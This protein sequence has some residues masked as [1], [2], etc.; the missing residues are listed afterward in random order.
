M[1]KIIITLSVIIAILAISTGIFFYIKAN[2]TVYNAETATGNTAGNLSNGGLFCEY[3]D[4]I[5][6][7]NPYDSNRLY[8]MN[9]DCTDARKLNDDTVAS[10]NV[11]G[12]YIYY[13]KNNFT[14]DVIEKLFHGELYGV[15]RC[16]LEGR[17]KKELYGDLCGIIS[18]YGNTLYYQHHD[19]KT[20]LSL[21]KVQ[22]DGKDNTKLYDISYSP[23][24][25][26]NGKI[27][28]S[29]TSNRN[30]ISYLDTANDG[31]VN[32]YNANSYLVSAVNGYIYYIDLSKGYSLVRLNMST[33]TLELLYDAED[34]KVINYNVYGNKIFF[35]VENGDGTGLYRMNDNGTQIELLAT[36]NITNIHCTS[37][38]TFFQYCDEPETL[39]RVP[40]TGAI[41]RVEQ[42]KITTTK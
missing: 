32:Y 7:A 8:V 41:T 33:K 30:N 3:E 27:Y 26:L 39:Y 12:K 22:I 36:G 14:E 25:V 29:D 24:S 16:D 35:Q 38:Y 17:N 37:Q 28:F 11:C 13:V 6:F 2:K 21:Y 4:K 20:A 42:I 15:Y 1:K 34:G 31:I 23:A 18:L 40:T 10:I 5:Y 19:D 9:S